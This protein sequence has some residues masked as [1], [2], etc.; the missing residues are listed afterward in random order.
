M[1]NAGRVR[2]HPGIGHRTSGIYGGGVDVDLVTTRLELRDL[3][4]GYARA[5]DRRDRTA[6]EALFAPDATVTVHR[7]GAEPHTYRGPDDIGQ[8][9]PHLDRYLSTFHLVANHWCD[10]TAEHATGEAYCQAHHVLVGDDEGAIDVVLT[11]RYQDTYVR[12]AGTWRFASREV[13]IL[14]TSETALTHGP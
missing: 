4:D 9:V 11:I 6:F 13:H 8:I 12:S 2:N 10:V 3:I 5:A 14:W 7:P 1:F